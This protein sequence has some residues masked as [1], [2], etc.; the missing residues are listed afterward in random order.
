MSDSPGRNGESKERSPV[1]DRKDRSPSDSRSRDGD[2]HDRRDK[3]A[4]NYT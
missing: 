3:D 1:R 2:R 4:E